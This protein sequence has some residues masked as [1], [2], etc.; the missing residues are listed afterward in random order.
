MRFKN[1][2]VR[3][4]ESDIN[5][6][7]FKPG[8]FDRI[9]ITCVLHHLENP[10][11][12]LTKVDRWLKPGGTVSIFLPCDPGIAVRLSRSLFVNPKA[13]RVGF[14]KY[15]LVNALEHRNHAWGLTIM[16]KEIFSKHE[17]KR[18]Y[19]PFY[20]PNNNFNL[21]SIWQITKSD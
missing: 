12:T 19:Y 14:F 9:I 1:R 18:R 11:L 8:Y 7:E 10:Y 6:C 13:K 3:Y 20:F 21:F 15:N 2:R 4:I 17:V 16:L 5:T